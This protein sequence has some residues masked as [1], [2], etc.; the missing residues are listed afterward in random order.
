MSRLAE[1]VKTMSLTRCGTSTKKRTK[2]LFFQG[3]VLLALEGS[4]FSGDESRGDK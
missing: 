1:Q 3:N 2:K 4:K